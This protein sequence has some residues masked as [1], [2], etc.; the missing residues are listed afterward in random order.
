MPVVYKSSIENDFRQKVCSDLEL[1][2]E[3]LDRYIVQTPISFGDG[4]TL[5]IV[6]KKDNDHWKLTDEG[7]T[8]L[9][10][11]YELDE[12][13][14]KQPSRREVIDRTILS[15]GLQNLNGELI[16]PIPDEQYGD[17]L[18]TF[19][20]AL[21]KIDDVRYLSRERVRS[22]FLEDFRDLM[23]KVTATDRVTFNWNDAQHDPV[24][25]YSVD[26]RING[27]TPPL[28]VFALSS[29]EKAAVAALSLLRFETWG[30]KFKGIGIF[31]EEESIQPRAIARFAD[32]AH[33]TFSN[34]AV[35]REGLPKFF[36]ELLGAP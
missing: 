24:S 20:Q 16:L 9:Q 26:C 18:Y 15:L 19:I 12:D 35:A 23:G 27:S 17:A 31:E 13:D 36:P 28:F 21:L 3:G 32:I 29:D 10:L 11:T 7:H 6:L 8:F 25:N 33:K 2:P 1:L 22:T 4:D 34:L 30:L 14:L 5:S